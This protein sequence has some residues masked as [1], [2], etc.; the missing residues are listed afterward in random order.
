MTDVDER[1]EVT[2]AGVYQ[3][4]EATYHGDP[5]PGRSL[6]SSGARRLL[7]PSCP[8]LFRHEQLHGRP[9]RRTF[10]F[11]H[12]AQRAVL[13]VGAPLVVVDADDWRTKAA[14]EQ[15]DAAHAAGHT[16][17]LAA[18][19]ERVE[20]MAAALRAHPRAQRL[21]DAEHGA[22]EQSLFRRDPETGVMLRSRLDWLPTASTGGRMVLA[23]YKTSVSAEPRAIA[24]SMASYGYHQ[25]AAWYA[26][27]VT[28]LGLAE[29]TTFVFVFQEKTAPYLVT[30]GEPDDEALAVGRARNREAI[31]LYAKCVRD[32]HWPGY[33]D[34]VELLALPTWATYD[35][36][37]VI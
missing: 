10:D 34:D 18:E 32:D 3:L 33:T 4:D 21:F 24:K 6:S 30:I 13:G 31:D 2:E 9:E 27:M 37:L 7:S 28:G 16:P 11:G 12:A 26:D 1:T 8:A 29:Q 20:G 25:Q 15:R 5:V 14:K 23:D 35:M 19:A 22:P 17:L 36:D